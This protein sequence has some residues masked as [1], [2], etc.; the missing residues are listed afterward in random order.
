MA[1]ALVGTAGVVSTGT[2]GAAV[3][4]V[5]GTGETRVAGNLLILA[6]L[7]TGSGTLPGIPAGWSLGRNNIAAVI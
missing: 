2:A 4:P 5:F 1:I 3:T 7:V 6:V